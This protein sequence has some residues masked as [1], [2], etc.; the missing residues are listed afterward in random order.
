[1]PVFTLLF[2]RLLWRCST[3]ASE[4]IWRTP[5]MR[6]CLYWLRHPPSRP[7]N[8]KS[9]K[10]KLCFVSNIYSVIPVYLGSGW[11]ASGLYFNCFQ[12]LPMTPQLY[13]QLVKVPT[14][15]NPLAN[16][17]PPINGHFLTDSI[18]YYL[19]VLRGEIYAQIFYVICNQTLK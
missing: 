16:F 6:P 5:E 1:M 18:Y 7:E 19:T 3:T 14:L 10:S 17:F 9:F 8:L 2:C 15:R 12:D 4:S 13:C 11:T